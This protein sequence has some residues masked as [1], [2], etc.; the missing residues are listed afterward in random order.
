MADDELLRNKTPDKFVLFQNYPNPFNP[1][2]QISFDVQKKCHVFLRVYDILGK[3]VSTL[4]DRNMKAGHYN[5][6]FNAAGLASGIY[7]YKI[8]MGDFSKTRKM[9]LSR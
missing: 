5:V 8:Q 3:Q 4:V 1:A 7:L 2:T 6:E 9:L